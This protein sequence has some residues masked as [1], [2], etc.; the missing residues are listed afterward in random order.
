MAPEW[1]A[2][3][4][5]DDLKAK[6][7]AILPELDRLN[8]N[9]WR[10]S[11][12]AEA[13]FSQ[14]DSLKRQLH[15]V[16][17]AIGDLRQTPEKLAVALEVFLRFDSL[18]QT[19]RMVLEAVRRYEPSASADQVEAKIFEST[20]ARDHFRRYMIDLAAER[21]RQ[22]EILAREAQRCR[23]EANLPGSNRPPASRPATKK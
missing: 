1:E 10:A 5:L 19:Q 15:S 23:T 3:R 22:L 8:L 4:Q 6:L 14:L 13:Y 17:A 16:L 21:D 18:D 12:A 9:Q 2:R 11:G 20:P 7:N